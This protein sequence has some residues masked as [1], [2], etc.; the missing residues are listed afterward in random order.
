MVVDGSEGC[1]KAVGVKGSR[2]WLLPKAW[3]ALDGC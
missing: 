1:G 3:R 2:N